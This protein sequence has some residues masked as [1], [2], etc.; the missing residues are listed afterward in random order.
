MFITTPDAEHVFMSA[1]FGQ[2][3]TKQWTYLEIDIAVPWFCVQ[4]WQAEDG[5]HITRTFQMSSHL[6]LISLLE[7]RNIEITSIDVALPYYYT[8]KKGWTMQPLRAIWR[9]KAPDGTMKEV[10]VSQSGRRFAP[11]D[12]VSHERDLVD[13][14]RI[15]YWRRPP[16]AEEYDQTDDS[17]M[18]DAGGILMH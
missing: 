10:I 3:G 8:G 15:F 12:G 17:A 9:G 5:A 6:Q 1:L 4:F 2:D 16:R 18:D 14:Q 13:R 7:V 11:D